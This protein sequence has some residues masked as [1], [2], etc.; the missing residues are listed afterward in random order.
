M[1]LWH[2]FFHKSHQ[3]ASLG[4]KEIQMV[5][6]SPYINESSPFYGETM[7][8]IIYMFISA[9]SKA[10]LFDAEFIAPDNTTVGTMWKLVR[11][12]SL[13]LWLIIFSFLSFIISIVYYLRSISIFPK[14]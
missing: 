12:F 3:L 9:L 11:R 7:Q 1:F 13:A 2:E 8:E 14:P 5:K 4:N 10:D 6:K